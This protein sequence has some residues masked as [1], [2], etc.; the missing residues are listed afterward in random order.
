MPAPSAWPERCEPSPHVVG[1]GRCEEMHN[2]A[3]KQRIVI[4][5]AGYGGLKAALELEKRLT[6]LR[7]ADVP[8]WEI[9]LIDRYDYHQLIVL[10]HEVAASSMP[11]RSARIP[12]SSLLGDKQISFMQGEVSEVNLEERFVVF[13]SRRVPFSQ[14]VLALG[15][16]TSFFGI[17]GLREN[18]FTLKSVEDASR[19]NAH[20]RRMFA[21]AR[22]ASPDRR[23]SML[24]FVV[25]GGGFTGT[26]MAGEMADWLPEMALKTGIP[27]AEIRLLVLEASNTILHGFGKDPMRW[28]TNAL[29]RR[30]VEL[31]L[32]TPVDRAEP[33]AIHLKSGEAVHTDTLIWTG[34]VMGNPLLAEWGLETGPRGM[35]V[36][37]SYMESPKHRGVYIIGDSS[38][39]LDPSTGKPV[40]PSAQLAIQQ[41]NRLAENIA[42]TFQYRHRRPFRPGVLGDVISVGRGEAVAAFGPVTHYGYA[43]RLLKELIELRYVYQIGGLRMALAR[44]PIFLR[45]SRTGPPVHLPGR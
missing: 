37:N 41:A 10:L 29:E 39:F 5:G 45:V 23:R 17:P 30:G 19:I 31:R 1:E 34:G 13:D 35:A 26:E 42:A 9:L 32:G 40:P 28:A 12:L 15:S 8:D 25:G 7:G 24:T 43:P 4:L 33:G 22:T 16:E 38:D 20:V 6:P 2:A 18:A 44:L 36:V 3:S 27:L 14:L 21:M 11:A